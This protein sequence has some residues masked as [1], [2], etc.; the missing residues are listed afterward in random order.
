M[1]WCYSTTQIYCDLLSDNKSSIFLF[2]ILPIC[3]HYIRDLHA[4]TQ[5]KKNVGWISFF[6]VQHFYFI[7]TFTCRYWERDKSSTFLDIW[8][9][10]VTY[11][12]EDNC[13]VARKKYQKFWR[14]KR[15]MSQ[16]RVITWHLMF[17][18]HVT[19]QIKATLNF[20]MYFDL[21]HYFLTTQ[22][23]CWVTYNPKNHK[24]VNFVHT[25]LE[26]HDSNK[27]ITW[28]QTL[29][30]VI[31]FTILCCSGTHQGWLN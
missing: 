11:D 25:T 29:L 23:K 10:R 13:L 31:A 14:L 4:S 22:H 17:L 1:A 7:G 15:D 26:P 27:T 18:W 3:I 5:M 6:W 9:Y 8:S 28:P 16:G 20:S 30:Q 21:W 12:C 2:D 19:Q 24:L